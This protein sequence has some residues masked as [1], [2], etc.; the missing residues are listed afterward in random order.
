MIKIIYPTNI[1][2]YTGFVYYRETGRKYWTVIIRTQH[3]NKSFYTKKEAV[4]HLISK[5]FEWDLPIKNVIYDH[6]DGIVAM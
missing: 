3:Y 5:N 2:K 4:D 1:K 6:G